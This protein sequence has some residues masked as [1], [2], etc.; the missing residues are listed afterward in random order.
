MWETAT[1]TGNAGFNLY[2][3]IDD[4]L[5]LVNSDM[6]PSRVIDSVVPTS[7]SYQANVVG[8][9]FYIEMINI[10]GRSE[11]HGPFTVGE[12]YGSSSHG[13]N[14]PGEGGMGKSLFLPSVRNQ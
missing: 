7:Y 9:A 10:A 11:L 1:E 3:V 13:P 4:G 14:G 5:D 12:A 6:I 2:M 8:A